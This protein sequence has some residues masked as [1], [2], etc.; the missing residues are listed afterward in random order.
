[1]NSYRHLSDPNE[2]KGT[3]FHYTGASYDFKD[4]PQLFIKPV[5]T[6]ET[7]FRLENKV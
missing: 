6:L 4:H 2:C 3:L 5:S 1:M 7:I